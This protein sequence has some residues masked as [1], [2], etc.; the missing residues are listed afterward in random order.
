MLEVSVVPSTNGG[1]SL[2]IALA[3][4]LVFA[5]RLLNE[6]AYELGD[7]PAVLRKYMVSLQ[8]IDLVTQIQLAVS[9]VLRNESN[10]DGAIRAVTLNDMAARLSSARPHSRIS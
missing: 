4:E 7:D 6:F 5:S 9:D 2:A 1:V 8:K 3:D 10:I